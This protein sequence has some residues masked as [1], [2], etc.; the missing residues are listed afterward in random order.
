VKPGEELK[1]GQRF[2]IMK[3]GSRMDVFVPATAE[4]RVRVGD[5]VIGGVTVI[6]VLVR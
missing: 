2:G 3:F 6:A 5:K 4:L 1:A